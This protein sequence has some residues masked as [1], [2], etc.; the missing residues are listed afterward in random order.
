VQLRLNI[1]LAFSPGPAPGDGDVGSRH[2]TVLPH[3]V[4][5]LTL[6]EAQSKNP[7]SWECRQHGG[8]HVHDRSLFTFDRRLRRRRRNRQP[9][10]G[11]AAVIA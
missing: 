1:T 2:G 10:A 8:S 4:R 7:L 5:K 9:L 6:F 3:G 11:F